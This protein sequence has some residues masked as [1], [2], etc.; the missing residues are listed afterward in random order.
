MQRLVQTTAFSI[1][2]A[3]TS[4]LRACRMLL[5]HAFT[6]TNAPEALVALD[7]GDA[8][9]GAAAIGWDSVGDPPA[10]PVAAHVIP[11]W[12]RHGVGRALIEA[13]AKL[14]DGAASALQPWTVAAEG[15]DTAAFCLAV[16]FTIHHRVLHFE[17]EVE[18]GLP[19]MAAYREKLERAGWIPADARVVPLHAAPAGDV[20]R[21]VC[22]V[23]HASLAAMLARL[24]GETETP[25][26]PERSVVLLLGGRVVG[27]QMVAIA[28]DG[29]PT[30]EAHVVSPRLRRGWA[31]ALLLHEAARIGFAKGSRR[32]R[33]VCDERTTDTVSMALR[34]GP[35]LTRTDLALIRPL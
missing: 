32:Y 23:F 24:R 3:D 13:A 34:T 15:S 5:P 29:I 19:M 26:E 7:R 10:F 2:R 28:S 20:A 21:L 8:L 18:A 4:D 16:G 33:F 9:I 31:N 30:V 14:A 25:F 1:V 17:S 22:G 27:A 35:T 12:R 6:A 11:P